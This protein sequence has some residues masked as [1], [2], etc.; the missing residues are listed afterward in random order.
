MDYHNH[1]PPLEL[2]EAIDDPYY[3]LERQHRLDF[4][5]L[6]QAYESKSAKRDEIVSNFK[7]AFGSRK[8]G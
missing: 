2:E 1:V 8:A 4:Q 7:D 3:L 6:R 5:L